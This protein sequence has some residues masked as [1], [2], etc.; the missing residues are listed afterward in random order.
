MVP[1]LIV[2]LHN[3]H[4]PFQLKILS[5]YSTSP[6]TTKTEQ[7]YSWVKLKVPISEK[8][9]TVCCYF[10]I[11]L[12]SMTQVSKSIQIPLRVTVWTFITNSSCNKHPI[13]IYLQVQLTD[14]QVEDFPR[15]SLQA[16]SAW[17]RKTLVHSILFNFTN[18]M[19]DTC[20]AIHYMSKRKTGDGH[21]RKDRKK[22]SDWI[23][24]KNWPKKHLL[25]WL[26]YLLTENHI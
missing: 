14:T 1:C 5:K 8:H 20:R 22:T 17:T 9:T 18:V 10:G 19:I 3:S 12:Y 16:K 23:S 13:F 21:Q 25:F 11:Y 4:F 15:S 26:L 2:L 6:V 24:D 7:Q